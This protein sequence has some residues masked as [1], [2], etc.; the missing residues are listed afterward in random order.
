MDIILREHSHKV[1]DNM[2]TQTL[3]TL[4]ELKDNDPQI[5]L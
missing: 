4:I 5:F 3:Y 1:S 2:P